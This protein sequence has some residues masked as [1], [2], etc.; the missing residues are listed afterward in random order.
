MAKKERRQNPSTQ[1]PSTHKH[2]PIHT[3]LLYLTLPVCWCLLSLASLSRKIP[4]YPPKLCRGFI[5]SSN[6]LPRL[7]P[8]RKTKNTHPSVP[9]QPTTNQLMSIQ[10]LPSHTH[11]LLVAVLSPLYPPPSSFASSKITCP[12]FSSHTPS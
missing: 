2:N 3:T 8:H 1:L 4:C 10:C 11:I 9:L 7:S 5:S 12:P 6:L